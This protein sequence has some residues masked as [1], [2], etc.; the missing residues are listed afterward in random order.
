MRIAILGTGNAGCALAAKFTQ[1]GHSIS[2]IKTSKSLHE[3]NFNVISQ[4]QGIW[5]HDLDES[6]NF[7]KICGM[8][9]SL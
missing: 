5:L 1:Q 9:K 8:L 6:Q 4:Q 2:L 7:V 3:E